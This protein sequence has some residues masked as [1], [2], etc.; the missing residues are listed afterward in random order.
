PVQGDHD[1]DIEVLALT[2]AELDDR[3]AS[4]EE[5]LDGKTVTAWFRA[6]QLLRQLG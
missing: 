3:L 2:P 5:P 4:G 1:E 6:S